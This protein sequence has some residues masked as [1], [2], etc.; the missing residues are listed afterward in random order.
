MGKYTHVHVIMNL[1]ISGTKSAHPFFRNVTGKSFGGF[2]AY[3]MAPVDATA[4]T[5]NLKVNYD[6]IKHLS[7]QKNILYGGS[8]DN[9]QLKKHPV[10]LY[11]WMIFKSNISFYY[12]I[13]VLICI[14]EAYDANVFI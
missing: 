11:H 3:K 13:H 14:L 8:F 10:C 9:I 7:H 12:R 1:N 5:A 2:Q 4:F 6:Y